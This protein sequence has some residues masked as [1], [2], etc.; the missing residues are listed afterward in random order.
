MSGE[1]GRVL[2][3]AKD[4][5]AK[6]EA[7]KAE[8]KAK[9]SRN[10][11]RKE[12][13]P[14][15]VEPQKPAESARERWRREIKDVASATGLREKI[16]D[17]N[18]L[19]EDPESVRD[20][21]NIVRELDVLAV[22]KLSLDVSSHTHTSERDAE[23]A[24]FAMSWE[25]QETK[26]AEWP[27]AEQLLRA[28]NFWKDKE[29]N[30]FAQDSLCNVV[31][32]FDRPLRHVNA[33]G[34]LA[35][36]LNEAVEEGL[37]NKVT[38]PDPSRK[39]DYGVYIPSQDGKGEILYLPKKGVKLAAAGWVFVRE[40]ETRARKTQSVLDELRAKETPGITPVK[41]S[42]GLPGCMFVQLGAA[43]AVLLESNSQSGWPTVKI[44]GS[45]GMK[46]DQIPNNEA[47]WDESLH[48]PKGNGKWAWIIKGI[49][50]WKSRREAQRR[51]QYQERSERTAQLTNLATFSTRFE[52]QG[53][54]RM[55]KGEPGVMA[56]WM[57]RFR[58][59]KEDQKKEA[60][61]GIAIE[62]RPDG[63]FFLLQVVSRHL[64]PFKK[65][66]GAQLPL[67]VD[68]E[69]PDVRLQEIS[70]RDRA[71]YAGLKMVEVLLR[72]RL[73]AEAPEEEVASE[74]GGEQKDSA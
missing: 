50:E 5:E 10:E 66:V 54:T 73:S 21:A 71:V 20:F 29:K 62:R 60:L 69:K 4:E 9:Q 40:V 42:N 43:Q 13:E 55:L 16:G 35:K 58:W 57:D 25:E 2:A 17:S 19:L 39:S 7:E 15:R 61:F 1:I 41:I 52:D 44:V 3:K 65:L 11:S 45:V 64:F 36:F 8:K 26:L 24:W 72:L 51:T 34:G 70:V 38:K 37:L 49:E 22:Y 67:S 30:A 46:P 28:F 68:T 56:I 32:R 6:K 59:G 33:L 48:R 23:E 27:E 63:T 47:E 31:S 14:E 18:S 53:L 74:E 12:A